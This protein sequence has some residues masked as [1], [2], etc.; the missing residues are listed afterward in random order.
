MRPPWFILAIE[1]FHH[2][3]RGKMQAAADVVHRIASEHGPDVIPSVMLAWVDTTLHAVGIDD[4]GTPAVLG[5]GE[6]TSGTITANSDE[7]SPDVAWAGRVINARCA[8]DEESFE[9]LVDAVATD[10]RRWGMHVLTL[11]HVCATTT[12]NRGALPRVGGAR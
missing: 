3:Q 9:A 8:D 4:Y 2:A 10:N 6:L 7:V 5:F 11:L 1:A 12:T